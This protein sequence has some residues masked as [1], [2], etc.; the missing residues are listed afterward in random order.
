MG[1][2]THTYT[3]V[4]RSDPGKEPHV[5]I[6]DGKMFWRGVKEGDKVQFVTNVANASVKVVFEST[7]SSKKLP[8]E[9][10]KVESSS[11]FEVKDG[12]RAFS[13]MCYLK[14]GTAEYGYEGDGKKP[15]QGDPCP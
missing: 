9:V 7:D 2:N 11:F 13:T 15:C 10:D 5:D 8:L 6:E 12:T 4:L 3:L 1:V 14:V